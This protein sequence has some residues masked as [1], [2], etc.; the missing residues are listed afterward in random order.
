MENKNLPQGI[1]GVILALV[2]ISKSLF[3]RPSA[4]NF[5]KTLSW[6]ESFS[7]FLFSLLTQPVFTVLKNSEFVKYVNSVSGNTDSVD[8]SY[9]TEILAEENILIGEFLGEKMSIIMTNHSYI[10]P[11]KKAN[12]TIFFNNFSPFWRQRTWTRLAIPLLKKMIEL[13]KI[14]ISKNEKM[15]NNNTNNNM[16]NNNTNNNNKNTNIN[17]NNNNCTDS[18]Y[19]TPCLLGLLNL[20]KNMPGNILC[21]HS[22]DLSKIIISALKINFE[23]FS[24]RTVPVTDASTDAYALSGEKHC[25]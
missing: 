11:E 2:W 17:E 3:M 25:F 14:N 12:F 21:S 13:N 9:S 20:T 6:Q 15:I 23:E 7:F 1:Q 8:Y 16:K 5:D 19:A 22:E 18:T 10:L 4:W 24:S